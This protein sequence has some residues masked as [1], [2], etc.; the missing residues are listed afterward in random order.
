MAQIVTPANP[1]YLYGMMEDE[2]AQV[3]MQYAPPLLGVA[4]EKNGFMVWSCLLLS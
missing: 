2:T 4:Q 3:D 1:E